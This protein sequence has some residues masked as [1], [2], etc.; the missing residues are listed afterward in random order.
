MVGECSGALQFVCQL[1][2]SAA[3]S[4]ASAASDYLLAGLGIAF[5]TAAAQIAETTLTALDTTTAIDLSATWLRANVAVIAAITLP[6]VVGLFV[7]QVLTSVLR[8]EPGGLARALV[9]VGKALLGAT[10]SLAVTQLALTAVDE[11]CGYIASAAGMTVAVAAGQFFNFATMFAG[12]SPVLQVLFGLALIVGFVLLWG[13][14]LFRKAALVLIAVFAPIAFAGSAWDQ[15]RVWTRR[16]LEIVAALVFCKVVIVVVF[17]VGAS[18][19]GG[20]GPSATGQVTGGGAPPGSEGLSDVLAG[21]LLL[22][23]AVFAPWLTWRFVHW[24]GM[25]A[26]AVMN[27]AVAANPLTKGARSA[28]TQARYIGQQAIVSTVLGGAGAASA[29]KGAASAGKGAAAAGKAGGGDPG[30]RAARAAATRQSPPA[31]AGSRAKG[32]GRS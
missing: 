23:I 18:A 2:G 22:S 12:S 8:R 16:W 28:A 30:V 13:V 24:S 31:P 25:E 21:L 29:G 19:F 3:G 7:V 14:L 6:V 26:A 11:I 27:S 1:T 10:L 32:G 9:G 5:L 17:V 20:T 15:T 4:A